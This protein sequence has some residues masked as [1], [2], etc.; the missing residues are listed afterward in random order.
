MQLTKK[1][2]A[3][4]KE[5]VKTGESQKLIA[6]DYAEKGYTTTRGKEIKQFTISNLIH[7]S[8]VRRRKATEAHRDILP[9]H[10]RNPPDMLEMFVNELTPKQKAQLLKK[11]VAS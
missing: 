3:K 1:D 6:D 5:R 10:L 11:L 7:R 9:K 2:I 8:K 4:I